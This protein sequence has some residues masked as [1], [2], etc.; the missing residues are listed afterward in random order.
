MN[1][2]L[3]YI[4]KLLSGVTSVIGNNMEG[5]A[6]IQEGGNVLIIDTKSDPYTRNVFYRD[7]ENGGFGMVWAFD[8]RSREEMKKYIKLMEC[9]SDK[10]CLVK[11]YYDEEK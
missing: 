5:D 1:K 4:L 8:S 6:L 7:N 2:L 3:C 10:H 9:F 11:Y